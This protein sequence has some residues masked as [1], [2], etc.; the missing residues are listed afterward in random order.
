MFEGDST[1]LAQLY[2]IGAQQGPLFAQ[3]FNYEKQCLND[4]GLKGIEDYE[5]SG[6]LAVDEEMPI[7]NFSAEEQK[8][9]ASLMTDIN[10]YV[11]E[12]T[13]KWILGVEDCNTAFDGYL[14]GLKD[15]GL[16]RMLKIQQAA[17]ERY[18]K[19]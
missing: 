5:A 18:L 19:K 9:L 17:Y 2:S 13:Q 11:S 16:D 15:M 14:N 10:T 7:L 1:V 12:H 6:L 3:E 8:E 4:E